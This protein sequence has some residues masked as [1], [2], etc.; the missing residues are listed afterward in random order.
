M[1]RYLML[2]LAVLLLGGCGFT[3]QGD[4]IREAVLSRGA[5]AYD[6]GLEGAVTFKCKIASIGAIERRYMGSAESWELW[7]NECRGTR[8][9]GVEDDARIGE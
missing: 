7:V 6:A 5:Q 3:P 1:K 9:L 4:V 8:F 2:G